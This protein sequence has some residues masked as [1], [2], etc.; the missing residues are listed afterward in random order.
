MNLRG[1]SVAVKLS[2]FLGVAFSISLNAAHFFQHLI[3]R[4]SGTTNDLHGIA[5]SKS[6]AV[7][8]GKNGTIITSIDG[9]HWQKPIS[10]TTNHLWASAV[11]TNRSVAV[12]SAGTILVSPDGQNWTR[13]ES[14]TTNELRSVAILENNIIV[15]GA[16]GTI[17]L[18]TN[19]IDFENRSLNVTSTLRSAAAGRAYTAGPVANLFAAVGDNGIILTSENGKNWIMHPGLFEDLK[20]VQVE[21]RGVHFVGNRGSGGILDVISG[22]VSLVDFPNEEDLVAIGISQTDSF[23]EFEIVLDRQGNWWRGIPANPQVGIREP[24]QLFAQSLELNSVTFFER[25]NF[26]VGSSGIVLS[27]PVWLERTNSTA[28]GLFSLLFAEEKFVATTSDAKLLISTN[29]TDWEAQ[30]IPLGQQEVP[31][32]LVYGNGT[33]LLGTRIGAGAGQLLRSP[34]ARVWTDVSQFSA[35][36]VIRGLGYANGTFFVSAYTGPFTGAGHTDY[37]W[38][39][40]NTIDWTSETIPFGFWDAAY[41]KGQYFVSAPP[42]NA[43][44]IHSSIDLTNWIVAD[45]GGLTLNVIDDT[46]FSGRTFTT[47]GSIWTPTDFFPTIWGPQPISSMSEAGGNILIT[48]NGSLGALNQAGK[49]EPITGLLEGVITGLAYGNNSFVVTTSRGQIFQSEEMPPSISI[50][51][52]DSNTALISTDSGSLH[53]EKAAFPDAAAWVEVGMTSTGVPLLIPIEAGANLF[54]RGKR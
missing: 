1:N 23:D 13:V 32:R 21:L 19:G 44:V 42:E 31:V 33:Y 16:H 2:I 5:A 26:A 45:E 47:D 41:F 6:L 15:V 3:Q 4:E 43:R 49:W 52:V 46:L 8:V 48:A 25:A 28:T 53:I 50:K 35:D 38:R 29:G 40:T 11:G 14:G 51:K 12:G 37:L 10:S 18:S 9:I 54:A 24:W 17:L 27:T 34:D 7:A 30:P 20:S 36:Q 22:Q 39:S